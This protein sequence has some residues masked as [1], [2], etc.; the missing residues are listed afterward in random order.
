[1]RF[2]SINTSVLL[3]ILTGI[4]ESN[5]SLF[6]SK[7]EPSS[8]N[9]ALFDGATSGAFRFLNFHLPFAKG[10][11]GTEPVTSPQSQKVYGGQPGSS[12]NTGS[13]SSSLEFSDSDSSD[14]ESLDGLRVVPGSSTPPLGIGGHPSLFGSPMDMRTLGSGSPRSQRPDANRRRKSLFVD[15]NEEY[16]EEEEFPLDDSPS[17]GPRKI[18]GTVPT[19]GR[20]GSSP[21]RSAL[22]TG[23]LI[24]VPLSD[25]IQ[26]VHVS[27]K[28][29]S[30]QVRL[31]LATIHAVSDSKEEID[32]DSEETHS[33]EGSHFYLTS[34]P[35]RLF[36]G[37]DSERFPSSTSSSSDSSSDLNPEKSDGS[38]WDMVSDPSS[39]EDDH[40]GTARRQ[41][42][43]PPVPSWSALWIGGGLQVS[44]PKSQTFE[45]RR[46]SGITLAD[47]PKVI[48]SYNQ[49]VAAKSL[50]YEEDP[51]MLSLYI[52][53][54]EISYN[55]EE[56]DEN[57]KCAELAEGGQVRK[58][59]DTLKELVT[60]A[61]PKQV[62]KEKVRAVFK[63][64]AD[65]KLREVRGQYKANMSKVGSLEPAE[66][67]S[68]L[69]THSEV[70]SDEQ[71]SDELPG[72]RYMRKEYVAALEARKQEQIQESVKKLE[73][74]KEK[75]LTNGD[76]K[77]ADLQTELE[78]IDNSHDDAAI[79]DKKG[80]IS[81]LIGELETALDELNRLATDLSS[82]TDAGVKSKRAADIRGVENV[83]KFAATEARRDELI[84]QLEGAS[85]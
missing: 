84:G 76:A 52:V 23:R 10:K 39:D 32:S 26:K 9:T 19:L 41:K 33:D 5:C 66:V 36:D 1:M 38:D 6:K 15:P 3:V 2:I 73:A 65:P 18:T 83:G 22:G 14:M 59:A 62:R 77:V 74:L 53:L 82:L 46:E 8:A 56:F 67:K 25:P 70:P 37:S 61:H 49:L 51:Y 21:F 48:E 44:V 64:L 11:V 30:D 42:D 85:A 55:K 80:E 78:A 12:P 29:K 58:A 28:K 13:P 60:A 57:S 75:V 7:K 17:V 20:K 27:A 79:K 16:S 45:R 71:P 63:S 40:S 24:Q 72:A 50:L 4:E 31:P 47:I 81:N 34:H 69:G 68:E 54:C 43:T 35:Y